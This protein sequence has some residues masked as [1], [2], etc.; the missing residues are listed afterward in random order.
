MNPK[1]MRS[2]ETAAVRPA[3]KVFS[4]EY[5]LQWSMPSLD[6]TQFHLIG[7][8]NTVPAAHYETRTGHEQFGI[9]V[10][11]DRRD[12]VRAIYGMP[13]TAITKNGQTFGHTPPGNHADETSATYLIGDSYVTFFYDMHANETVRSILS[14]KVAAEQTK[15][16]FF[17]VP[18]TALRNSFEDLMPELMNEARA[19][20]GLQP[21]LYT[22]EHNPIARSHSTSMAEHGYFGHA[23]LHQLRGGARMKKGGL[24]FGWWGENL[25]YGQ[26][27]AIHAHEAL[28]NSVSHRDNILRAQFTHVFV[29]VAFNAAHQPYFTINFYSL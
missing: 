5:D 10:G 6:Y 26:F 24:T 9:A 14:V 8:K 25:A 23:D 11:A 2:A 7:T 20:A 3:A 4:A 29:G 18:S 16:G 12:A 15:P 27:S 19:H 21:L 1:L 17:A 22:P 28:M 13:L